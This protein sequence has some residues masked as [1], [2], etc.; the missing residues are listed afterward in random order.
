MALGKSELVWNFQINIY[1]ELGKVWPTRKK[2]YLN[3]WELYTSVH[4][5]QSSAV[6]IK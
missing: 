6:L 5:V 2:F 4:N 3:D 1:F